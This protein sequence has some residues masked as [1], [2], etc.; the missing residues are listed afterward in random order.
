MKTRTSGKKKRIRAQERH[1]KKSETYK[2][3]H[4]EAIETL[5]TLK[6]KTQYICQVPGE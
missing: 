1:K 6:W 2:F 3:V 5:E 4:S